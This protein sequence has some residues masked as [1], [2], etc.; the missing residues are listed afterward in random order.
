[1]Q[2]FKRV[3]ARS[4]DLRSTRSILAALLLYV[5][6]VPFYYFQ[7][8]SL[9]A[10]PAFSL[11]K[12]APFV[13]VCSALVLWGAA[14]RA[15][16]GGLSATG[17]GPWIVLHLAFSLL[18]LWGATYGR[19]GLEKWIYFHA[20]GPLLCWLAVQCH[21]GWGAIRRAAL[22]LALVGGGVAAYTSFF[23]L[24]GL[25][26][27]WDVVQRVH[28]P[29]HTSHRAM[30]PFGS[31]VATATCAMLLL[32][33]AIWAYMQ[34]GNL[35]AKAGWGVTCMLLPLTVLLT[36]TRATQA[37]TLL[38]G[39]LLAP[40][41]M[42]LRGIGRR[43]IYGLLLGLVLVVV[44]LQRASSDGIAAE[45]AQRWSEI[46]EY[47]AVTIRDGDR[48]YEYG[49]LLEYTERFRVAQYYTV[50]NILAVHPLTGVG[51]GTFT[52]E[53][54]KYRYTENYMIREFPEHTTEN[55]Y[56][57]FLAETGVLGLLAR[58]ALM[59]AI[60]AV[61]L[62]SWRRAR[63]GPRRDLLWAYLAS[64]VALS[65]HM[66]TWDILNEPTLRMVYWLWTGLALAAAQL[67]GDSGVA[68]VEIADDAV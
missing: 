50:G 10:A 22:F 29:Y 21:Q 48:V 31:T 28:N 51:F 1:M 42:R 5:S 59:A 9:E 52:R 35:W 68:V 14:W 66:L 38:C 12:Y 37:A 61:V 30:G 65:A 8:Q 55:M 47:R 25:E 32:P 60:L 58:L 27:A 56:L 20:T 16:G 34:A 33:V 62:R 49:S 41:L 54:E 4:Q 43:H 40:W 53:F 63:P 18:S 3:L 26:P 13:L 24:T 64:Y 15:R 2:V 36:Q 44:L 57:M 46:L 6:W 67:E 23:A 7:T 11:V 19:I 39:L 45:I 17:V